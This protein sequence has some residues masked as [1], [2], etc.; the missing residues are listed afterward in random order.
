V[1]G[2][3]GGSRNQWVD[4]LLEIASGKILRSFFYLASRRALMGFDQTKV[5]AVVLSGLL[6]VVFGLG[7]CQPSPPIALP[8]LQAKGRLKPQN[9]REKVI[10]DYFQAIQG[11]R[12]DYAYS[13]ISPKVRGHYVDF[14]AD[15]KSHRQFLPTAIAIGAEYAAEDGTYGYVVYHIMAGSNTISHGRILLV[16]STQQP[17]TWFIAYSSAI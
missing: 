14:V 15:L 11:E 2:L 7:S 13:L 17:G 3:G 10:F 5:S 8:Q 16:P 1:N 9:S 12:Y 6:L 4:S